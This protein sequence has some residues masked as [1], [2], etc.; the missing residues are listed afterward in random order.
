MDGRQKRTWTQEWSDSEPVELQRTI[1]FLLLVDERFGGDWAA[2]ERHHSAPNNSGFADLGIEQSA[3]RTGNADRQ[4]DDGG[5]RWNDSAR[6]T[7]HGEPDIIENFAR[8]LVGRAD[9]H[10]ILDIFEDLR[11][12][13]ADAM[14]AWEIRHFRLLRREQAIVMHEN[15]SHEIGECGPHKHYKAE[16]GKEEGWVNNTYRIAN[17]QA[18]HPLGLSWEPISLREREGEK[19]QICR[20]TQK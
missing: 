12:G 6:E 4:A 3:S 10:E 7:Q 9:G 20:R 14:V 11:T 17:G 16:T 18:L 19:H 2:T 15:G 1:I 13:L 5:S 8:F